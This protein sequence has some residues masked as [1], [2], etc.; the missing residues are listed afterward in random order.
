MTF[1][2]DRAWRRE[3]V[4]GM[5]LPAGARVLDVGAGTGAL[6]AEALREAKPGCVVAVDFSPEMLAIGRGRLAKERVHWLVADACRLP[7]R[8]ASFQGVISGFLLRNVANVDQAL[9]EQSRVLDPEGSAACLDTTAPRRG[10]LAPFWAFYRTRVIPLLGRVMARDEPAYR[11]L[12]DSTESFL[13]GEAL[14]DRIK[15]AGFRRVRFVRRAL[16]SV[17]IHWG[18]KDSAV[19]EGTLNTGCP[20]EVI[21]MDGGGL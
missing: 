21:F 20:G 15:A 5:R 8:D 11:Y 18:E 6:S 1:G 4:R 19:G 13:T 14:A 12:A 7:F 9:C 10:T 2:Q 17:A 3:T 16:G